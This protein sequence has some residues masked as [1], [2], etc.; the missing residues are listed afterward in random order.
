MW[1]IG[2]YPHVVRAYWAGR[3]IDRFTC[4][5]CLSHIHRHRCHSP[6]HNTV[7]GVTVAPSGSTERSNATALT[8]APWPSYIPARDGCDC[9]AATASYRSLSG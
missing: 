8:L 7:P 6:N 9:V 4:T 3:V 5:L 1:Q 2:A